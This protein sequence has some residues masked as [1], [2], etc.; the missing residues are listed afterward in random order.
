MK[1]AMQ[2]LLHGEYIFFQIKK[3]TLL[4]V[5][6]Q[7]I[8]AHVQAPDFFIYSKN[9]NEFSVTYTISRRYLALYIF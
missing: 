1:A 4:H 6:V 2:K 9:K 8:Q 7:C 3:Y 5:H